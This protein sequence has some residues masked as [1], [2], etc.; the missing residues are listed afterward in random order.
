MPKA[1]LQSRST[2]VYVR[3]LEKLTLSLKVT[4]DNGIHLGVNRT[5]RTPL[6]SDEGDVQ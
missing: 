2:G 3:I 5:F 1:F 6:I 4:L